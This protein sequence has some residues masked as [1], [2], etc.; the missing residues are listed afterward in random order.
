MTGYT[1][2]DLRTI[3]AIVDTLTKARTTN[4][5]LGVPAAPD[6]FTARFPNG[7]TAVIR[8]TPGETSNAVGAQRALERSTRHRA[9]YRVD[10]TTPVDPTNVIVLKDP[11]PAPRSARRVSHHW[12]DATDHTLQPA[13]QDHPDTAA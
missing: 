8:W 6:T 7:V 12:T 4:Q 13:P 5:R 2:R 1:P 11:Q 3:A 9:G 10:F